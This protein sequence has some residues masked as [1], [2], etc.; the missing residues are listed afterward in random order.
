MGV[1]CIYGAKT[2]KIK[3]EKELTDVRVHKA[4]QAHNSG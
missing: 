2:K 4:I 1:E 3:K